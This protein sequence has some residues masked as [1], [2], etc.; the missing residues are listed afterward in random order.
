MSFGDFGPSHATASEHSAKV[1]HLCFWYFLS[2]LTVSQQLA[3]NQDEMDNPFPQPVIS[4]P[5]QQLPSLN[6]SDVDASGL[7]VQPTASGLGDDSQ[8]K[9]VSF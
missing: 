8:V 5:Q 3:G 6:F 2:L 9:S 7:V 1:R 4:D